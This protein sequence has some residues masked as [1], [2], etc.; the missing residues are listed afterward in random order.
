MHE[1]IN[2]IQTVKKSEMNFVAL[3]DCVSAIVPG[4]FGGETEAVDGMIKALEILDKH[5]DDDKKALGLELIKT[6]LTGVASILGDQA[7]DFQSLITEFK[8]LRKIQK[9]D[10]VMFEIECLKK[11]DI[12]LADMEKLAV[13]LKAAYIKDGQKVEKA[14]QLV[15][16]QIKIVLLKAIGTNKVYR[17]TLENPFLDTTKKLFKEYARVEKVKNYQKFKHDNKR[18]NYFRGRGNYNSYNYGYN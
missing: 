17:Y 4:T 9:P 16:Q 14:E 18:S 1:I 12:F 8:K 11:T 6:R 2:N 10:D 5:I 7:A 15:F 3:G 13:K